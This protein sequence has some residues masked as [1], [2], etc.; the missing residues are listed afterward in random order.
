MNTDLKNLTDWFR[1]NQLSVN[2]SQTKYILFSRN[3]QSMQFIPDMLLHID[4]EHLE[5]VNSTKFLGIHIDSHLTWE[6]HIE[7]CRSKLSSGIYAIHMS[8]HFLNKNHVIIIYYRLIHPH[9]TNR[10]NRL[11]GNALQ[12]YIRKLEILQKKSW[13]SP[14]ITPPRHHCLNN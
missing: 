12:K 1:A 7:H 8:K 6:D 5:R 9:L 10:L 4:N 3:V 13:E 11:W 2:P 14:N